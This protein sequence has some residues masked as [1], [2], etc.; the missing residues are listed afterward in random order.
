MTA[1]FHENA[2]KA[3]EEM[4]LEIANEFNIDVESVG[5]FDVI[6]RHLDNCSWPQNKKE[7]NKEI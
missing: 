6:V 7:S 5:K 1:K 3:I 4:K 2:R